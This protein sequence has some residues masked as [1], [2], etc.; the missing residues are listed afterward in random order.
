[1]NLLCS[2]VYERYLVL[3]AISSEKEGMRGL[4]LEEED[5]VGRLNDDGIPFGMGGVKDSGLRIST[6]GYLVGICPFK[7]FTKCIVFFPAMPCE[8][9]GTIPL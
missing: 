8:A 9:E 4:K 1:M 2:E 3:N 5:E 6:A 7:F